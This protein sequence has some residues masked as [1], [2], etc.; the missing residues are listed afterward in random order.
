MRYKPYSNRWQNWDYSNNAY[1]FVTICTQKRECF[2]GEIHKNEM[3]LSESGKIVT[4]VFEEIP[5]K[6]DFAQIETFVVMPNHFHTILAIRHLSETTVKSFPDKDNTYYPGG[7]AGDKN[8]LLNENLGRIIH[9]F[10]GRCT[11]E[12]RKRGFSFQ[13]QANYYDHVIRDSNEYASIYQYIQDNPLHWE[14][15]SLNA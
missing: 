3:I 7:F 1:Y 13:W 6:F 8:P 11:Y 2:L 14:E 9:W 4:E 5:N 15:D 12:I 10:K